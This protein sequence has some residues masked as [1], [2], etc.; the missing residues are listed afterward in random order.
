LFWI[1]R[2]R[3]GWEMRGRTGIE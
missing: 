3:D 2:G 1:E